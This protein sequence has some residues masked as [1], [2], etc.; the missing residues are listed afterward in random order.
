M[1]IKRIRELRVGAHLI[2][3]FLKLLLWFG[4]D[5]E[6]GLGLMADVKV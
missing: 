3:S 4:L 5:F 6:S 1:P 2:F